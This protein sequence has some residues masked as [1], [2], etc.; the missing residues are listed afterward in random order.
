LG[1]L[2]SVGFDPECGNRSAENWAG[3]LE[4]TWGD[5]LA[6][7]SSRLMSARLITARDPT[8]RDLDSRPSISF[9]LIVI[10]A[11]GPSLKYVTHVDAKG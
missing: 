7:G 1:A 2:Q 9:A 3:L 6:P 4:P 10:L 11:N 5:R 8:I